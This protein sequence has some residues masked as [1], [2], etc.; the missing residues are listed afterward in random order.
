MEHLLLIATVAT[1]HSLALVSPGPNFLISA[2]H[3]LS[4]SSKAGMMTAGG[5]ATGTFLHAMLGF[6]GMSAIVAQSAI[7]YSLLKYVGAA[8]LIYLGIKSFRAKPKSVSVDEVSTDSISHLQSGQAYR[9]GFLTMMANPKAAVYFLALFTTVISP[10]TPF[11]VKAVLVILMP[12][13]SWV[14]YSIVAISFSRPQ[15]RRLYSRFQ[16]GVDVT[17][18][19][20]MVALGLKIAFSRQ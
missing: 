17:F 9:I 14:W 4:C 15:F 19:T 11:I 16:R 12:L 20:L 1:V 8:Y 10:T 7:V 18:G 6:L 5:I 3:G 2:K 13:L